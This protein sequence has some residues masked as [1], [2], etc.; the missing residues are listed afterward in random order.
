MRRLIEN[1]TTMDKNRQYVVSVDGND[2]PVSWTNENL[3]V[4]TPEG[5][6]KRGLLLLA[7]GC[8]MYDVTPE[9]REWAEF[10]WLRHTLRVNRKLE[11]QL[12][13]EADGWGE[14]PFIETTLDACALSAAR[15]LIMED[16]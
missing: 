10:K 11:I 7:L 13:R 16:A 6:D 14:N 12:W 15:K 5:L 2:Y 8:N 3:W 9:P 1:V 4:H